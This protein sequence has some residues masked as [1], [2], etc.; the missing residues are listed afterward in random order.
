VLFRSTQHERLRV[1]SAEERRGI[2]RIDFAGKRVHMVGICGCGMRGA[3]SL[4]MQCG[5][6]V[7]GSDERLSDALTTL[8]GRAASIHIG[9]RPANV[10]SDVALVVH[11]AAVDPQNPELREAR[12]L[13]VRVIKYAELLGE[14][15]HLRT[16]VAIAGTHGK[17]TTTGLCAHVFRVAGLDPSFIVGASSAQLGGGSGVGHGPHFIVEACEFDRSFLKL[18]P[19]AATILNVDVDHLDCYRDLADIQEAFAAFARIVPRD[20]LIVANHDDPTV[21]STLAGVDGRVE[22]I[23]FD[24]DATWR[25]GNIDVHRGCYTFDVLHTGCHVLR[26]SLALAGRHNV[27]NALAVA[28]LAAN[29]GASHDAIREGLGSFAG[30]DRRMSLRGQWRGVTVVDDY[31]H[32][33]TEI[34]VTLEAL[35]ERFEPHRLWV[36]FQPHQHSRTRLLMEEFAKSFGLADEVVVPD[37]YRSRDTDADFHNVGSRALVDRIQAQGASVR[38]IPELNDVVEALRVCTADGDLVVTMGAGDVWKVADELVG[39]LQRKSRTECA[40]GG[41][42]VVPPGGAGSLP[43]LA[44]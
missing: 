16:G 30:V 38:Y 37:I 28:A 22:T 21:S 31:A 40:P 36:V 19:Y 24:E 15:M 27:R 43:R 33:P 9:H 13:G 3:A 10:P 26:A 25:A 12:R 4:L 42:D 6:I 8:C 35:R 44:G 20:G 29:L 32:H 14:L 34:R 39:R 5:A 7:S 17:S 23:G 2:Q 11:S 18:R 1:V 41:V